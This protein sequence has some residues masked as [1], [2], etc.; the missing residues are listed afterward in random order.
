MAIEGAMDRSEYDFEIVSSEDGFI[1]PRRFG[2]GKNVISRATRGAIIE[3]CPAGPTGNQL[4]PGLEKRNR[5]PF[6]GQVKGPMMDT[7]RF[8]LI[9]APPDHID[10]CLSGRRRK[11]GSLSLRL[12]STT[13]Y[14]WSG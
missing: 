1:L 2:G 3:K 6:V 7:E 10:D 11:A 5:H 13:A 12:Q 9:P 4:A 14:L 8:T